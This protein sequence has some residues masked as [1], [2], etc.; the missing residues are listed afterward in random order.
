MDKHQERWTVNDKLQSEIKAEKA[1]VRA[2]AEQLQIVKE[3]KERLLHENDKLLNLLSKRLESKSSSKSNDSD[4]DINK[5]ADTTKNTKVRIAPVIVKNRWTKVEIDNEEGTY[6]PATPEQVDKWSKELPDVYKQPRKVWQFLQRLQKIYTLHPLDGAMVVNVSLRD[7][8]QKRLTESVERKIGKSQENIED[9]W[10]AVQTFLLKLKPAEVNWSKITSCMQKTEES[11]VE[12]EECFRQ[13]WMEHSGVNENED[14]DRDT[15]MPLKMAFINGLKPEIS[16]ALQ[17]KYDDWDSVG[18]TFMQIVEWSAKMERT[19][20]VNLRALQT[21][22][23]SYNNRTP[24]YEKGEYQRHSKAKTVGRCRHCNKE[25]HWVRDWKLKNLSLQ[26]Q[27]ETPHPKTDGVHVYANKISEDTMQ[28]E[29]AYTETST[30]EAKD[31][32]LVSSAA[33]AVKERGVPVFQ[34]MSKD[35]QNLDCTAL[36]T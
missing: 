19:Q 36:A 25:G 30:T 28:K 3:D 20:E 21:K 24:W 9:G 1:K 27:L 2:L 11:V 7:N 16:K 31:D 10:E 23:L 26:H 13:T 4:E 5:H 15:G 12:F 32:V 6:Q 18:T 33:Q 35:I 8:D 22:T 17:I 34:R 14:L 29:E